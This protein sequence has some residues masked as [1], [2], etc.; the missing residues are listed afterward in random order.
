LF[1]EVGKQF[2]IESIARMKISASNDINEKSITE[3]N[4]SGHKIDIYGIGT[5]LV[6][7]Q[8]QPFVFITLTN[9]LV[10]Y[11]SL[12]KNS[13]NNQYIIS[14]KAKDSLNREE[15]KLRS[16]LLLSKGECLNESNIYKTREALIHN[17]KS[18]YNIIILHK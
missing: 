5:N 12:Y 16:K 10:G 2:G 11:S 3:F 7:C 13:N 14:E 1:D 17:L 4:N 6:T 9:K 8:L 18:I 15:I